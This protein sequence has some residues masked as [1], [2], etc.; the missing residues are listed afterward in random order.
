MV[1]PFG[2]GTVPPAGGETLG[3]VHFDPNV[4]PTSGSGLVI[5][6]H[7]DPNMYGVKIL[8]APTVN[9]GG[10]IDTF[11]YT[12]TLTNPS[13]V[14]SAAAISSNMLA[15]FSGAD[16]NREICSLGFGIGT[17]ETISTH[18]TE[19]KGFE[20]LDGFGSMLYVTDMYQTLS[21][22]AQISDLTGTFYATPGPL[23]LLGAGTA[24][25]FS[26]R[27]RKRIKGAA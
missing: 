9:T 14:W 10:A 17:C 21:T 16:F 6:Q 8:F 4:L 12:L 20:T 23:P 26:R 7:M 13:E 25:G 27:L 2:P 18:D 19:H 3:G 5:F 22:T 15:G 24:F 11:T 1:F